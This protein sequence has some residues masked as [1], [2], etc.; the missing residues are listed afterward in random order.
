MSKDS[1]TKRKLFISAAIALYIAFTFGF[2]GPMDLFFSNRSDFPFALSDLL[3]VT[4][5]TFFTVFIFGT[6]IL[7]F[8]PKKIRP[9]LQALAFGGGICL[10]VQGVFWMVDYGLLDGT[11]VDWSAYSM[12]GIIN[13]LLWI[14]IFATALIVLHVKHEAFF[15]AVPLICLALV[16]MQA[17]GLA[18]SFIDYESTPT[19][20]TKSDTF[21]FTVEYQFDVSKEENVVVF[22]LDCFDASAMD[23]YIEQTEDLS[24]WNDFTYFRNTMGGATRT[25]LAIPYILTGEAFIADQSYNEYLHMSYPESP[26]LTLL[27]ENNYHSTIYTNSGM[28]NAELQPYIENLNDDPEQLS[29]HVNL[30]K[31]MYRLTAY[32]YFPQVL[33]PY[34]HL[35][36]GVFADLMEP[37]GTKTTYRFDDAKFFATLTEEGVSAT[38]DRPAFR[39]YHLTGAH[40]PYTL[41]ESAEQSDEETDE[42]TQIHGVFLIVQTYIDQLKSLGLYENATIVVMADHGAIGRDQNPLFMIKRSGISGDFTISEAPVHFSDIIPTLRAEITGESQKTAFMISEDEIRE[43]TFFVNLSKN[44][45]YAVDEYQSTAHA[46]DTEAMAL[47]AEHSFTGQVGFYTIGDT[48]DFSDGGSGNLFTVSGFSKSEGSHTWSDSKVSELYIPLEEAIDGPLTM[49]IRIAK[50]IDELQAVRISVNGT[51]IFD[52]VIGDTR[53]SIDIPAEVLGT[54]EIQIIFEYP[55]ATASENDPRELALAFV[56]LRLSKY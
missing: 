42:Q 4:I 25:E 44:N 52:G 50:I 30:F 19:T 41:T 16:A 54:E 43:R 3:Q 35:Y 21:K 48:I 6:V 32:Q 20:A 7:R 14:A 51:L 13:L 5:P 29:S 17:V 53:F 18:V 9:H 23:T 49:D 37:I 8:L 31:R 2:F 15:R 1:E 36:S 40:P 33:K 38:I 46:S 45:L 47:V 24:Q 10:Y 22:V 34:F 27:L 39:F 26:L 56:S 11:P 28:A 12:L 55:N